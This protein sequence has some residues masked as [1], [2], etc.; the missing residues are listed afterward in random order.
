MPVEE[1]GANRFD[2]QINAAAERRVAQYVCG[3]GLVQYMAPVRL[4]CV[5]GER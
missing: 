1:V 3:E 2:S 5:R 4:G